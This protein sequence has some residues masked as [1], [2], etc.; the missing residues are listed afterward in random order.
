MNPDLDKKGAYLDKWH[1]DTMVDE[2]YEKGGISYGE[3]KRRAYELRQ[4]AKKREKT[5]AVKPMEIKECSGCGER[6]AHDPGDYLCLF[7]RDKEG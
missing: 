2:W 7:C 5:K 4:Q 6:H 1:Y 3:A